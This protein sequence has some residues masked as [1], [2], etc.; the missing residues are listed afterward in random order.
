MCKKNPDYCESNDGFSDV[1][2]DN[3]QSFVPPVESTPVAKQARYQS[4]SPIRKKGGRKQGSLNKH[5][6]FGKGVRSTNKGHGV[7]RPKAKNTKV[8]SVNNDKEKITPETPEV[9]SVVDDL[10]NTSAKQHTMEEIN[11]SLKSTTSPVKRVRDDEPN[12]GINRSK[13]GEARP[14]TWKKNVAKAARNCGKE[15]QFI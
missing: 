14:L 10:E 8:D 9:I 12:V 4:L 6:Q 7:K 1:D 13:Q 15:Y 11:K 3:D 5:Q 2:S